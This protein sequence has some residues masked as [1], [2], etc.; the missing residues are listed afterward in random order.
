[1]SKKSVMVHRALLTL[2]TVL[3][4]G[5][6]N[7]VFAAHHLVS[8]LDSLS[9]DSLITVIR[10]QKETNIAEAS[11]TLARL[12]K[13]SAVE[14][15]DL[16]SYLNLLKGEILLEQNQEEDG[17]QLVEKARQE[18]AQ[19]Q[20]YHGL[21][22]VHDALAKFNL[23]AARYPEAVSET[24]KAIE[25]R[26]DLGDRKGLATSLIDLADV[27]WY[28]QRFSEG[29][30]YGQ[31]AVEK[32]VELGPS[33]ELA[34]AYKILSECYL[35][36]PDYHKA[37]SYINQC[38]DIKRSLNYTDIQ[39]AS[40]INSRGNVFKYLE[41]YDN[42]LKD[43]SK[44]LEVCKT[45]DYQ[46][47]MRASSANIG[48]VYLLMQEYAKA[49]PYKLQSIE[50]QK[51]TGQI[52][53]MAENTLHLSQAYAGLGNFAEA[54]RY[55]VKLDSIKSIEH[56]QALDALTNELGVKYETEK[57]EEA[58][59]SLESR[60]YFQKLSLL[61]GAA[62]L[63]VS[64]VAVLM[65]FRLNKR[66]SARNEEN[67]ILLREIHHRVKNNLQILSS[68]LSLQTDHLVDASA[69]HAITEGKN[70]VESMGMIHQH[71]YSENNLSSVDM[72]KYLYELSRYLEDSFSSNEQQIAIREEI[73]YREMDVDFAIPL[74]LIINEL[75]TN[76]V[77]YAFPTN[78]SGEVT[79]RLNEENEKLRLEVSDQGKG[80]L[81]LDKKSFSTSFGTML[82]KTLS[83]KL[84]GEISLDLQQGY[85]TIINF[86]RFKKEPSS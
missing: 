37:L 29:I 83:K 3:L 40:A 35:E 57:K 50:I 51:Q 30:K 34:S 49:I 20:N 65:F 27:Y 6:I 76:A 72:K 31:M 62:L 12:E 77:K 82:V 63:L 17:M 69:L 53:Q 21:L 15:P 79:I 9:V 80:H 61:L 38:I 86:S 39:L 60:V 85:R 13:I 67:E 11:T 58:I 36:L 41:Q 66:L 43:Y 4:F 71:L 42:A 22:D 33:E 25:I 68:L 46:I 28:Y 48:H 84:K 32:V 56:L 54:Y 81:S 8:P 19:S 70:R 74:G 52:Q 14:Y 55:F 47:C 44:V 18:F 1:M 73:H 24:F 75:V 23:R 10:D 45:A 64:L 16:A 59:R 7:S 2:N 78:H 5:L 26:E